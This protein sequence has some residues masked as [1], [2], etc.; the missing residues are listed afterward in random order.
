MKRA[1]TIRFFVAVTALAVFGFCNNASAQ[2]AQACLAQQLR[3]SG[4]LCKAYARCY[5]LAMKSGDAL[6]PT[7]FNS[8]TQHLGTRFVEIAE[9]SPGVCLTEG[10]DP[11]VAVEA[12]N[13]VDAIAAALTLDGGRCAGKK[14][15]D[16][17]TECAGY[18][19]CYA[20]GAA[21]S[22]SVDPDCLAV[23]QAKLQKTFPRI[24]RKGGCVVNGDRASLEAMVGSL[25]DAVFVI[26]RGTGTTTTTTTTSSSSTSTLP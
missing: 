24:E 13:G 7:C 18:L 5:A 1:P 15:G 19:G 3:A 21:A 17:G 8:A 10:A 16:L 4:K 11:A 25:A 14:I 22:S 12:R 23:R 2:T 26:L 9:L 6:D 20:A